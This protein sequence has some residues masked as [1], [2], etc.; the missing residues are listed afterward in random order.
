M[1]RLLSPQRHR[2][3]PNATT[4]TRQETAGSIAKKTRE[5]Y[6]EGQADPTTWDALKR[7]GWTDY[8]GPA[9]TDERGYI[10]RGSDPERR[11]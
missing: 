7:L 11:L 8:D 3:Y 5:G 9:K 6:S 1:T 2:I 10:V 4:G